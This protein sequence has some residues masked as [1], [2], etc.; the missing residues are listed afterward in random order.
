MII[1]MIAA[2]DK[3]KVIGQNGR[4]PWRLP[5]DMQRFVTLTMGKPVIMGR[6]TYESIPARFRPLSG[7]TNIIITSKADY[8]APGCLVVTSPE[9]ALAAAGAAA[10]VMIIGGS[11]IYQAFLFQAH[12]LYLTLIDA[13]FE[14]DA[15]FPT[16]EQIY[17]CIIHQESHQ[18]DEKNQYPYQF[19]TLERK[20]IN[21]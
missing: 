13:E 17:W 18:P 4:L 20:N 19:L 16:T 11:S 6:K 12:R 8:D 1:S 14:G 9:A 21:D 7:R 5:A 2:M 10:E 3:N 15:I